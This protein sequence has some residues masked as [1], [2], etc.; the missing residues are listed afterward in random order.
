MTRTV[1][2]SALVTVTLAEPEPIEPLAVSVAV[3]VT[4]TAPVTVDGQTRSAVPAAGPSD[5]VHADEVDQ[6]QVTGLALVAV[7]RT[8]SPVCA[9]WTAASG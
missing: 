7:K 9:D 1:G 5:R 8:V 4:D 2:V 6:A 3:A